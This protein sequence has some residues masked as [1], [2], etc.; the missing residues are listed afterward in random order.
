MPNEVFAKDA[1]VQVETAP[2]SGV[3]Q[4]I[5]NVKDFSWPGA[6]RELEDV[7]SHSTVGI[8]REKYATMMDTPPL[9]FEVNYVPGNAIHAQLHADWIST[10]Q[11]TRKYRVLF[12]SGGDATDFEGTVTQFLRRAPVAGVYKADV[13]ILPTTLPTEN[14]SP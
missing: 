6:E 3:Y 4:S 12:N 9:S 8:L 7:T 14:P 13:Q 10:S 5:P 2:G 1:Q 11:I